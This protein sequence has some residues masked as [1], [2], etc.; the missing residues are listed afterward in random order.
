MIQQISNES[1]QDL[2]IFDSILIK[3]RR[4]FLYCPNLKFSSV[5][6]IDFVIHLFF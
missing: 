3:V 4:S 5:L 6:P 1:F 2:S